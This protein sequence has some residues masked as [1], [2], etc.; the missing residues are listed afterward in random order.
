MSETVTF[1]LEK[2]WKLP[3]QEYCNECDKDSMSLFIR[4]ATIAEM[5]RIGIQP[6]E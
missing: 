5:K 4:K 3:L 2:K 1:R 6:K